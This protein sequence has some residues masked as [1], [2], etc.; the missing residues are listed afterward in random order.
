MLTNYSGPSKGYNES[1][2][3]RL[4]ETETVL[5][6]LLAIVSDEQLSSLNAFEIPDGDVTPNAADKKQKLEEWATFPLRTQDDILRWRNER[7]ER[8]GPYESLMERGSVDPN[9]D[10][11]MEVGQNGGMNGGRI[12]MERISK[13]MEASRMDDGRMEM[14]HMDQPMHSMGGVGME[15]LPTDPMDHI[16]AA[17]FENYLPP[18]DSGHSSTMT[19]TAGPLPASGTLGLS[20]EFQDTFLW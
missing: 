12:E 7:L 8:D 2:E 14:E 5:L 13:P 18:V 16:Q 11:A 6:S 17:E 19:A 10:M 20:K 3:L 4:H 15:G 9:L 1:L